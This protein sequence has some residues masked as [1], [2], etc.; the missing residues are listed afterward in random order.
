M[1]LPIAIQL[2]SVRD[3]MSEDVQGTLTALKEMGYD[4]VEFAGL[5]GKGSALFGRDRRTCL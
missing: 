4:G 1:G 5:Y 3:T 2:F